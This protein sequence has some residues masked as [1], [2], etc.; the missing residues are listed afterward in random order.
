MFRALA[1]VA[2]LL[3]GLAAATAQ[4]ASITSYRASPT[5]S[6]RVQRSFLTE[7]RWSA[8][9][10]VR[11]GLQAAFAERSHLEIWQELVANEGLR[12]GSVV[13]ALTAYWV[14]NWITANGAYDVRVD[15]APVRRQL[16]AAFESDRAFQRLGDQQKQELAEGYILN[17]LLEH[18]ALYSALG[19]KDAE[20][21]MGLSAAATAR[22]RQT[23]GVDL[24][25][26]VPGPDGFGPRPTGR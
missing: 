8:G 10:E 4:E 1:S 22:F 18:A 23:M 17:F 11:D 25:A 26:L 21:L 24:L 7:I 20:V 15:H 3:L 2:I 5:V 16:E 12:T 13:D 19:R 14:L 9:V 6:A